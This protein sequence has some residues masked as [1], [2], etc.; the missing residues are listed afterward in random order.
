M[1]TT[2]VSEI[3]GL[4]KRTVLKYALILDVAYTGKGRRKEYEWTE[5]DVNKLKEAAEGAKAG[6][7]SKSEQELKSALDIAVKR[8]IDFQDH[9]TGWDA[10]QQLKAMG[11]TVKDIPEFLKLAE[12]DDTEE[13]YLD[14]IKIIMCKNC[15]EGRGNI[16]VDGIRGN[17]QVLD[18]GVN[19]C[20]ALIDVSV[21]F[22]KRAAKTETEI[23][24]KVLEWVL[25]KKDGLT[26][27]NIPSLKK[28][29]TGNY[30]TGTYDDSGLDDYSGIA[31]LIIEK[32]E[33]QSE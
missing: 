16:D 19:H 29:A 17:R 8:A 22:S 7:P 28:L 33:A 3:T 15:F 30:D 26:K 20:M 11:Y 31:K 10:A 25:N 12:L 32:L 13:K 21:I 2:E 14:W 5:E 27:D 24:R 4:A 18:K 1:T 23:K 6:R 9:A